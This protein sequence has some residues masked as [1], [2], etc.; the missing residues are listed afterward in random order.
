MQQLPTVL[1]YEHIGRPNF[2]HR[3]ALRQDNLEKTY[4]FKKIARISGMKVR[5]RACRSTIIIIVR[6]IK[7]PLLLYCTVIKNGSLIGIRL[8]SVL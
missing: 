5:G 1:A 2:F 7:I 4:K 8:L 3:D 6:W